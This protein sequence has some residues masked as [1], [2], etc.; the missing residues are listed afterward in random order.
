ML[1]NYRLILSYKMIKD[2]FDYDTFNCSFWGMDI[3]I[4]F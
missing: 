3:Q 1:L 2:E 4:G